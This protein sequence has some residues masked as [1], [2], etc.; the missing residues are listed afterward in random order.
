MKNTQ[1]YARLG[2]LTALV[3]FAIATIICGLYYITGNLDYGFIGYFFFLIAFPV[4]II[5]MI[6]LLIKASKDEQPKRIYRGISLM[7][8]NIPIAIF[9]FGIGIYFI[10]VMRITIENN[11]GKDIKNIKIVGC[12]NEELKILKNGKSETFWIDISGDCSIS[13]SYTDGNGKTQDET[14]VGYVTSGM[15]QKFTYHVGQ[16]ETGW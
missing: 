1:P 7:L 5:I 3:T 11:T 16:G 2:R 10:G 15:G 4:N 8:L 14:V 12:E 13:M 9:Y 6:I